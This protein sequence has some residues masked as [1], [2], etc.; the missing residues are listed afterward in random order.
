MYQ[1][2]AKT[3]SDLLAAT[4]RGDQSAAASYKNEEQ[5]IQS[6]ID[7][8]RKNLN[9]MQLSADA[10]KAYAQAV[11]NA[12]VAERRFQSSMAEAQNQMKRT[13]EREKIQEVTNAISQMELAY[14]NYLAAL[15]SGDTEG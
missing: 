10:A 8:M 4:K 1:R 11:D 9:Q 14:R 7:Q 5:A 12:S 15:K 2:L 6:V 13:A 3:R